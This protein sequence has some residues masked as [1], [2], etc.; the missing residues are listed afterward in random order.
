MAN[1]ARKPILTYFLIAVLILVWLGLEL[2]G[3]STNTA[4]LLQWGAQQNALIWQGETWRLLT[5]IFLHIGF[6]HLALNSWALYIL[7]RDVEILFG[8]LR[9]LVIFLISGVGGNITY[10]LLSGSPVTSAG[11][12]GAIFGLFGALIYFGFRL[13]PERR[14]H[15]WPAIA[16]PVA[17]NL[18]FGLVN[19]QI[20]NYAHMGGLLTG[21]AA[22]L[23]VGLPREFRRTSRRLIGWALLG[24]LALSAV[25]ASGTARQRDWGWAYQQ[26]ADAFEAGDYA[27]ASRHFERVV[28]LRPDLAYA[29]YAL[30]LTYVYQGQWEAAL[31]HAKEAERL[32]PS[33][34]EAGQLREQIEQQLSSDGHTGG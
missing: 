2:Q 24:A 28:E 11:A 4:V 9:F 12:S 25:A 26:G 3:G 13:P 31:E 29:H 19:P 15:F 14:R 32:D 34:P 16:A 30:A 10:L 1:E 20:N 27:E 17:I 18:V 5:P 7:G 8:S 33:Q 22:A 6:P 21:W 23:A